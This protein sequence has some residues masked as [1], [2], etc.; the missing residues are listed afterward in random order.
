MRVISI[1]NQ[2]GGVGKTTTSVNLAAALGALGKR[3]LLLDLDPQANATTWMAVESPHPG[4][5][6]TMVENL[7][8]ANLVHETTVPNVWMV[9]GSLS[10][11][12]AERRLAG[13][14][15]TEFILRGMLKGLDG[16]DFVLIDC[17]PSLGLLTVNALACSR[18][19]LIPVVPQ[20]LSLDGMQMLF[21]TVEVVRDR[22]NHDLHVSGVL[23]V[24]VDAR[25]KLTREVVE[26]LRERYGDLVL[27]T[28]IRENVRLAEAPAHKVP[29]SIHDSRSKGA[30]DYAALAEELV[31]RV[32]KK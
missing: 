28:A 25:T 15:G 13:E 3:V 31:S 20:I 16:Y 12:G 5:L 8:L 32:P 9:P 7:P 30:H 1:L 4:L 29:I 26:H 17:P 10:L 2:K 24:R 11:S 19:V 14:V 6:E 18:E 23:L 27:K 21:R 22:L